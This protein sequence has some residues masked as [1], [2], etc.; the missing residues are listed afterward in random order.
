MIDKIYRQARSCLKLLTGGILLSGTLMYYSCSDGALDLGDQFISSPTYTAMIDSVSIALS[1]VRDDSIVTSGTE[2]GLIGYYQHPSLGGQEAITYFSIGTSENFTWDE[3]KEHFDSITFVFQ[4]NGYSIGDTTQRFHLAIH[5]LDEEIETNDD[6][7][8]Y[9][10]SHFKYSELLGSKQFTPFPNQKKEIEVTLKDELGLAI[11]NFMVEKEDLSSKSAAFR[12]LIKGFALVCDT[13]QTRSLLGISATDETA[14]VKL[15]SHR[16]EQEKVEEE[17]TF[18]LESSSRQFYQLIHSS[19]SAFSSLKSSKDKLPEGAANGTA[20]LQAGT[21]YKVRIDFPY[22]NNLLEIKE[23]GRIVKAQLILRPMIG[24]YKHFDLPSTIYIAAVDKIN[25]VDSYLTDSE[26]NQVAGTLEVDKMYNENTS[27]I[28]DITNYLNY[29]I[30]EPIIDP[31]DGLMLTFPT[32]TNNQ[33][34][35]YV[36]FG[37]HFNTQSQSELHIYYYYYDKE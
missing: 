35:D 31:N 3:K 14:Y 19:E 29:R 2:T 28:Y 34:L 32:S 37:G 25:A 4:P 12:E 22:L 10:T 21:G 8:L 23:Q 16:V 33:T 27:Y 15:Y 20:L 7:D 26:G 36:S 1:T 17:R 30:T 18:P 5:Q 13:N 24:T 6:G 11:I 9:T